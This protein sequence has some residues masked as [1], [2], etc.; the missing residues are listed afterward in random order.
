MSVIEDVAT[1]L[2]PARMYLA[3]PE[4]DPARILLLGHGA[5]GGVDAPDL[6]ALT[7]LTADGTAVLR[8]EQPWRTA[9]KKIAPAPAR[10]DQGWLAARAYVAERWPGVPLALGGRSA[11]ARVACRSAAADPAYA[12]VALSFPLHPP[13]RP[14]SSRAGELLA[15]D[16]PVLVLQGERDPFGTPAEVTTAIQGS[17]RYRVVTVPGCAHEMKPPKRA[18]PDAAGVAELLVT[19]VRSFL[20]R[21]TE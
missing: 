1:E 17:E 8:F 4:T 16:C 13:G 21:P 6:E 10:L 3:V 5:G 15:P 12:V 9:G 19:Q 14:E 2:G 20:A 18:V 7:A 11:G